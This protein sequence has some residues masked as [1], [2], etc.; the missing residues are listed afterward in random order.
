MNQLDATIIILNFS[1][2]TWIVRRFLHHIPTNHGGFISIDTLPTRS[3]AGTQFACVEIAA[4]MRNS[5]ERRAD[6]S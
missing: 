4:G 6:T 1:H 5:T 3:P 2:L